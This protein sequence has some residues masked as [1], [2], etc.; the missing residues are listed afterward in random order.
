MKM[1]KEMPKGF[2]IYKKRPLPVEAI[3][4][5]TPFKVKSLEGIMIAKAGDYLMRGVEG[6][7]YSCD[8]TIFEKTYRRI[9]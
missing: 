4:I 2:K 9:N 8:K 3:Q 6:E 7:L 5:N 1:F